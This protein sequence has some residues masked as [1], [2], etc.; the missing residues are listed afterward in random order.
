MLGLIRAWFLWSKM[1]ENIQIRLDTC[2]QCVTWGA[3]LTHQ[4]I[5]HD[6]EWMCLG[7]EPLIVLESQ[8][9]GAGMLSPVPGDSTVVKKHP[10]WWILFRLPVFRPSPRDTVR[11]LKF[12]LP[13]EFLLAR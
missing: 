4:P 5:G 10:L 1:A 3:L 8:T 6:S 13:S 9:E 2:A 11:F 7:N 12:I